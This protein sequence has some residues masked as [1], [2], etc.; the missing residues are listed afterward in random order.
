MFKT[1]KFFIL[2]CTLLIAAAAALTLPS[3]SV[4]AAE[5]CGKVTSGWTRSGN[6]SFKLTKKGKLLYKV[7]KGK[8]KVIAGKVTSA[9]Y[10]GSRV[11]YVQAWN[12][13]GDDNACR[14][15]CRIFDCYKKKTVR[16]CVLTDK[17]S[18]YDGKILGF[19]NDNIV[20]TYSLGDALV[21]IN[22]KKGYSKVKR[23]GKYISCYA[24]GEQEGKYLVY[25]GAG[26]TL[27]V[28]D[29][30]TGKINIISKKGFSAI[31]YKGTLYYSEVKFSSEL[32]KK[33]TVNL[34]TCSI[35][36]KGKKLLGSFKL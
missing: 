11:A 32:I 33:Q 24:G 25:I 16:K 4:L 34:Y 27:E 8:E 7:G 2:I 13:D 20:T 6:Y 30:T 29:L 36:G 21:F 15:P 9:R 31:I 23:S 1:K 18:M 17:T 35:S 22:M 12:N 5:Q 19:Y 26:N 10:Q 3:S 28:M 14:T